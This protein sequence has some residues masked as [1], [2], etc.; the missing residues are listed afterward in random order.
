MSQQINV[1]RGIYSYKNQNLMLYTVNSNK[2]IRL[3]SQSFTDAASIIG[4]QTKPR[5][6]VNMTNDVI[7]MESMPGIGTTAKVSTAGIVCFKA[8]PYI[9]ATAG[10]ITGDVRGYEAS[11]GKPTGAGTI[12]GAISCLKCVHNGTGTVTGG[13]YPI[14]VVTHGDALAWTGFALL[15]DVAGMASASNGAILAN[16]SNTT[17]AGYIQ[18]QI[19]TPASHTVKYIALYDVKTS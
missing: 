6:A 15:P 12:T 19:G 3:N 8:E 1:L 7:G 17:N 10:T 13:V 11:V 16:I 5:A 4:C 18:V 2:T 14:H 9:H